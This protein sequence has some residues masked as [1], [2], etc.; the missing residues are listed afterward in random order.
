MPRGFLSRIGLWL[1]GAVITGALP[2]AASL[3]TLSL[4][5]DYVPMLKQPTTAAAA[6]SAGVVALSF[7]VAMFLE[8]YVYWKIGPGAGSD[9]NAPITGRW[10]FL[11]LYVLIPLVPGLVVA[12]L[13]LS[14]AT[15]LS[16]VVDWFRPPSEFHVERQVGQAIR[17]A[18]AGET[19]V[20][21]LRALAQFGS[22]DALDELARLATGDPRVLNDPAS[23]DALTGALASFGNQAEPVLQRIWKEAGHATSERKPTDG[24]TPAD[25]VLAAYSRLDVITDTASAYALAREA[26][27]SPASSPG[28]LAEAIAVVAKSGSRSDVALL[29]SFLVDRPESVKQAALDGLRHLDARLR[30]QEAPPVTNG[31]AP[32]GR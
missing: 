28:Q 3:W 14:P 22:P 25:V 31:P 21:G 13:T 24:R 16:H 1:V 29:A 7:S 27:A 2:L 18:E 12:Y 23:F 10:Q 11:I 30:K 20:A 4:A 17:D 8:L 9:A 15:R 19:R 6:V 32:A 5:G 26:A